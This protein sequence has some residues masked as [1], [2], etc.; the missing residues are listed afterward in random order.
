LAASPI[1]LW[2]GSYEITFIL[3]ILSILFS[4]NAAFGSLLI[5]CNKP[6]IA[7]AD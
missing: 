3:S 1:M 2:A 4:N 5:N 6:S 7:L